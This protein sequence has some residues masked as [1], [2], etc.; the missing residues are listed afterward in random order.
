MK[1]LVLISLIV[2]SGVLAAYSIGFQHTKVVEYDDEQE[3]L[4]DQI[5]IKV[6]HVT[7]ENTPKGRAI[8]YFK[9][10]V[11]LKSNNRIKVEIYSNGSLYSD[12]NEWEALK[13]N[14]VQMIIPATSKVTP[15]VPE[16]AIFDLPFAFNNYHEV[17]EAFEGN[18]GKTL[19][20]ELEEK[21]N[22]KTFSFWYNGFKQFSNSKHPIKNPSDFKK[23]HFRS[24]PSELVKDQFEWLGASVSFI[25]FNRIYENLEVGFID[26]QE[27]TVSNF[28][29]KKMYQHQ[30]YLTISNH[31]YLGYIVIMNKDFWDE[32]PEDA[33]EIIEQS[34]TQTTTW[35]RLHSIE[36]NDEALRQIKKNTDV[37]VVTLLKEERALF[38]KALQPLYHQYAEKIGEDLLEELDVITGK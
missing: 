19:K 22:V 16:F 27:N 36:I 11:E 28:Q 7:A 32:L 30:P 2:C 15:Y 37:E 1:K 10:L 9:N 29:T 34:M 6:S 35:S 4:D 20:E 13:T 12:I 8:R 14:R 33:K 21:E 23:L 26:G 24:M 3:K 5:V 31:S 18:I 17:Q 25:P 38:K